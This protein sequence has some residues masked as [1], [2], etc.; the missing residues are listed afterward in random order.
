MPNYTRNHYVPV[1]YQRRFLPKDAREMKF[2]YL[3]LYPS[4]QITG[5]RRGKRNALLRWGPRRCFCEDDLYT[6]KFG[7]WK[8]TEIEQKFFGHID[9]SGRDAVEYFANFQHPSIEPDSLH[10]LLPY[11]SVQKLR[12]PKGLGYLGQ[13]TN[14]GD[15]NSLLFHLQKIQQIFCATWTECIWSLADASQSKTKF[16]ISDHPVTVYN[17]NCF[18]LSH[19]CKGFN[20]PDIRYVG[21]HTL[22]PLSLETILIL[23]NLSWIRNPYQSTLQIRPNPSLFRQTVFNFLSIQTG[24]ILSDQE[25][26]EINYIIKNRA[27][28]Y[29]AAAEEEWLYPEDKIGTKAWDKLGGGYL[30]MPDPRSVTFSTEILFGGDKGLMGAFDAYGRTP[31]HPDY[32]GHKNELKWLHYPGHT[33]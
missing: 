10:N 5:S 3:D 32:G 11:M 8:S 26:N 13:K 33:N 9:T 6:T 17:R 25:V 30:L 15:K 28:R 12:T 19:M 7:N 14:L 2:Y 27:Y 22:F 18:P 1:W 24:R 4:V 20:D 16:I 31:S 23:T 29:I 21:T